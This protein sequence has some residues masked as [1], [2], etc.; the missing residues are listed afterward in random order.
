M[1]DVQM[2]LFDLLVEIDDICESHDIEY[3][4][5]GGAALGALRCGRFL[6]WDDDIDLFIT[7]ENWHKLRD[8]IDQ[9]PEILPE[10]RDLVCF[11]NTNHYRNPLARYVD[12]STTVIH[13]A[14]SIAAKSCGLQVEFFILDPIPNVEDGREEHLK[15]MRAFL[16]I[17]VPNFLSSKYLPLEEFAEHKDLVFNYFDEIESRGFSTVISELYDK[18][19]TYPFEKA[20]TL[21]L[22]WGE[23]YLTYKT[24][25]FKEKRFL[26]FEGRQFPVAG[27]L[28]H[29]YR[30]EFGDDWIYVP[31]ME[32]QASHNSFIEDL[33][34]PFEDYTKIYLNFFNQGEMIKTYEKIKQVN[35][36]IRIPTLKITL[37]KLK[38]LGVIVKEELHKTIE[39]N[40]YDLSLLLDNNEFSLLDEIF[41]DYYALQLNPNSR[42]LNYFVDIDSSILKIALESKIKQ[43]LYFTSRRILGIVEN[44]IEL[45]EDLKQLKKVCDYCHNLSVSIYDD[46]DMESLESILNDADDYSKT[47]IDTYRAELHLELSKSENGEDYKKVIDNGEAIL[48]KFPQDGEI[49]GII[50]KAYFHLGENEKSHELFRKAVDL[51]RNGFVWKEAKEYAGIDRMLEEAHVN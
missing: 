23:N 12:T 17:L 27:G 4:L 51:T 38:M 2:G 9:N 1:N 7:R 5:S 29:F 11:E 46:K 21:Y 28:E 16:E 33:N 35:L 3:Y 40:N 26:D 13:P 47:L 42:F 34:H 39:S 49:L 32:D 18:Y 31:E 25:W 48:L 41:E 19:Y 15:H 10:N 30:V 43:G 44:N 8:L 24:E 20:D 14:Q 50:A 45:D 37:E 36:N 22:R 6:P